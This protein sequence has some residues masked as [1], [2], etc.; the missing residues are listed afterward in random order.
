MAQP[1]TLAEFVEQVGPKLKHPVR[2]M[3]EPCLPSDAVWHLEDMPDVIL[4]GT[5]VFE[6]AAAAFQLAYGSTSVEPLDPPQP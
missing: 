4:C 3:R 5:R 1:K 2:V 6:R